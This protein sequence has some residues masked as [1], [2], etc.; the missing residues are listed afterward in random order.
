MTQARTPAGS[1]QTSGSGEYLDDTSQFP[2]ALTWPKVPGSINR[3]M[4]NVEVLRVRSKADASA[5]FVHEFVAKD[6]GKIEAFR[7]ENGA[8]AADGSHGWELQFIN[9]DASSEVV[10]YFGVGTGTEAAKATDKA[11]C[12]ANA[13]LELVNTTAKNFN[14]GNVIQ[15]TADRDGTAIQGTI[16]LVIAY[17]SEGTADD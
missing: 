15:V 13:V 8:Q 14:K 10:G 5:D 11:A 7:I 4:N 6:N 2:T 16:E 9:T 17:S 1:A 12:A 3:M